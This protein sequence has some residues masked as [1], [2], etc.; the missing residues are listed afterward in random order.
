MIVLINPK[1][2]KSSEEQKLFFREPNLGLLYLAAV[3]DQN[4]ISVDILDLEQFLDLS[5]LD[6]KHLIAERSKDYKIFG[7]T[8]LTNTFHLA[9]DISRII[10]DGNKNSL[11]IM[12]GP[13]VTFMYKEILENNKVNQKLIDFICIG[14][15]ENS[16]L[17]LV[18]I[19]IHLKLDAS[20]FE[21]VE[22]KFYSIPGIA[23]KNSMG[24]LVVTKAANETILEELPLPA[25]YKLTHEYYYYTIA[26]II[27]NRG[28]PNQCSFCSRQK[29]FKKT[30]IRS[31][32]SILSEIRD[33]I[34]LQTYNYINF[35][36]N[37]NINR[38][39]FKDFCNMFIKNNINIPWGCEIRVDVISDKDALLL[40]QA[41]C[42]LIATGIESASIDVLQKNFKYQD[43]NKV[44]DG[45]INLKKYNIPVQAYFVLGLPGETEA[46]F[47]QT[48][49][50]I[51]KLPL[52]K[53]DTIDYFVATPYPGS[54]LWDNKKNI[55]I[56]IIETD[57][58]KYDCNHIIF[59]TP[60]LNLNK[61][62]KLYSLAKEIEQE[63]VKGA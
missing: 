56:R 12:G 28:C 32:S 40:K 25:R 7:I 42:K 52:E 23:F 10:K 60:D 31:I 46:T 2:S 59:E 29:L 26:N 47:N 34:S 4:N 35:Y 51:Q 11:I 49:E 44:K 36:D 1:T 24:N 57:F 37:I 14:E 22:S 9:L 38:A 15:A 41:G 21:N 63:F 55:Q 20:N 48:L 39:F 13:H 27:V 54:Q 6:L 53:G 62:E 43:P 58:S 5:D 50:Y 61:L 8:S 16:F 17:Q 30:K 18:K 33:I 19:L 3:L 45:L